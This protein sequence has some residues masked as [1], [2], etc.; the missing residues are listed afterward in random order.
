MK[1]VLGITFLTKGEIYLGGEKI[2]FNGYDK[3]RIGLM[4]EESMGKED[5][6]LFRF[7]KY[8]GELSEL[9]GE[10]IEKKIEEILKKYNLFE[11]KNDNIR[12]LSKGMKQRIKWIHTQIGSPEL[13]MLD[14]PTVDLDPI[15]KIEM[16]EW[17]LDQKQ[18]GKTILISSHILGEVEKICDRFIILNNGM[19]LAE[20]SLKNLP[21][22]LDLEEYFYR[23]IREQREINVSNKSNN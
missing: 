6:T 22:G 21:Q 23:V 9:K 10:E 18:I 4:P 3:L 14:E 5:Y 15:G 13:L 17:I 16:R 2:N 20:H 8:C 11:R 1:I 12:N 7:L 19:K